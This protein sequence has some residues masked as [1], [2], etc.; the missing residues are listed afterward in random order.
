VL[1]ANGVDPARSDGRKNRIVPPFPAVKNSVSSATV[2]GLGSM[3]VAMI[4]EIR[5]RTVM[6]RF[7]RRLAIWLLLLLAVL[8]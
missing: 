1:N 7:S 6:F 8:S 4:K 3:R 5:L 2:G